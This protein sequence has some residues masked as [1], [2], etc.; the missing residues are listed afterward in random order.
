MNT[1]ATFLLPYLSFKDKQNLCLVQ[2]NI[3]EGPI[4]H[5]YA[6]RI[7]Y[8]IQRKTQKYLHLHN[9]LI[10]ISTSIEIQNPN[11][12]TLNKTLEACQETPFI[13]LHFLK[14]I[15]P[16]IQCKSNKTIKGYNNTLLLKITDYSLDE[17]QKLFTQKLKNFKLVNMENIHCFQFENRNYTK[18]KQML[19][20]FLKKQKQKMKV[21]KCIL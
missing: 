10:K 6:I 14:C 1:I 13:T 4:I 18:E 11:F 19:Y 17:I 5:L 8:G 16:W 12:T 9:F 2:K 15:I 7:K 20:I 3:L 21:C